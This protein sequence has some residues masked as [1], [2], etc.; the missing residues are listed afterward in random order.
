MEGVGC[1]A[2]LKIG[3]LS[4]HLPPPSAVTKSSGSVKLCH[5]YPMQA[6]N[7]PLLGCPWS[8]PEER[9]R[10]E[11]NITKWRDSAVSGCV[12]AKQI[13]FTR[14][15]TNHP[16]SH[17]WCCRT[18]GKMFYYGLR[19]PVLNTPGIPVQDQVL[20]GHGVPAQLSLLTKIHSRDP[21]KGILSTWG[22]QS[23]LGLLGIH[24]IRSLKPP[25][26]LPRTAGVYGQLWAACT[27]PS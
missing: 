24:K 6:M 16:L 19:V 13:H 7:R 3:P 25:A 27:F 20:K 10:G 22:A 18:N 14:W 15:N 1:C 5:F 2:L 11:T 17:C 9:L 26:H 23:C 21:G 4:A 12:P 8:N